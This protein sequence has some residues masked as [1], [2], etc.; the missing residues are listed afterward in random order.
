MPPTLQCQ[1]GCHKQGYAVVHARLAL[2]VGRC[3]QSCGTSWAAASLRHP[4]PGCMRLTA[5]GLAQAG[6]DR[7]SQ[8]A[9]VL[10]A[11]MDIASSD[12]HRGH[13]HAW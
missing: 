1:P 8:A 13:S 10:P 11:V 4:V 6:R 12:T 7:H 3:P 9:A 5:C 2:V